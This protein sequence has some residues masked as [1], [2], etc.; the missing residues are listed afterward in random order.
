MKIKV[1]GGLAL[2]L[3]ATTMSSVSADVE[4]KVVTIRNQKDLD[5]FL[6]KKDF[7]IGRDNVVFELSESIRFP[8][9]M[10]KVQRGEALWSFKGT[11]KAV[12][13]DLGG[14][15]F[16]TGIGGDF[17]WLATGKHGDENGHTIIKNG[18][19]YGSVMT[20]TSTDGSIINKAGAIDTHSSIFSGGKSHGYGMFMAQFL[21]ASFITIRDMNFSNVH[22][23]DS[24]VFD[25]AGSDHIR[26]YNNTFAGYGGREFTD[27]VIKKRFNKHY[28][29]LYSE[30]VQIDAAI[31]GTFG[32]FN[33]KGTILEGVALDGTTSNN[34]VFEQ[35]RFTTYE[36]LDGEG[37]IEADNSRMIVRNFSAGIGS[38][39]RGNDEFHHIFIRNNLFNKTMN[40]ANNTH[41]E[42]PLT[43]PIHFFNVSDLEKNRI[44]VIGNQFVDTQYTADSGRLIYGKIGIATNV[45][46][47]TKIPTSFDRPLSP[48]EPSLPKTRKP[49]VPV[50]PVKPIEVSKPVEKSFREPISPKAPLIPTAPNVP[51]TVANTVGMAPN[52]PK[53]PIAP[54][55]PTRV[56]LNVPVEPVLPSMTAQEPKKPDVPAMGSDEPR[57]PKSIG[58]A[59][60]APIAPKVVTKP[61]EP[62]LRTVEPVEPKVPMAPV[63][64]KSL[65]LDTA[66]T[67]PNKPI[68]P[69]VPGSP[70]QPMEPV[71]PTLPTKP[72]EPHVV[73]DSETRLSVRKKLELGQLLSIRRGYPH[74]VNGTL[75]VRTRF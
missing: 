21:K 39:T 49:T 47:N 57:K 5:A 13:I 33:P 69:S 65:T 74:A 75:S 23:E 63:V 73:E 15:T 11:G 19:F 67:E 34:L 32:S 31:N 24:H 14:S 44:Y 42:R 53:E 8:K 56:V 45:S 72:K 51:K 3:S 9:R 55:K 61:S 6:N 22:Y 62:V 16:L 50:S 28:H 25:L 36:G 29:F 2:G 17:F 18:N 30:A 71:I 12:T 59:P 37:R 35:N 26:F 66:P 58:S 46:D 40:F 27:D 64:P 54:R 4:N 1:I 41:G 52:P 70:K 7:D 43:Y 60:V 10:F 20:D 68:A 48:D 38:H